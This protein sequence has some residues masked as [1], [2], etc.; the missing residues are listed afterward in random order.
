MDYNKEEMPEDIVLSQ[1]NRHFPEIRFSFDVSDTGIKFF[2]TN[3][4]DLLVIQS[5]LLY[6]QIKSPELICLVTKGS[7][8]YHDMHSLHVQFTAKVFSI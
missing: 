8:I 7:S 1:I 2:F 6:H 5:F 3:N 4:N